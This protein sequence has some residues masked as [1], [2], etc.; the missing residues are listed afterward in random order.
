MNRRGIGV[1][2]EDVDER[3]TRNRRNRE[4][5]KRRENKW[6]RKSMKGYRQRRAEGSIDFYP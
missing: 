1:A 4:E 5:R 3:A 2:L 6:E